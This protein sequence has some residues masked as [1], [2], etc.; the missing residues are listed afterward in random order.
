VT[1]ALPTQ[2]PSSFY[3]SEQAASEPGMLAPTLRLEYITALSAGDFNGDGAVDAADYGALRKRGGTQI[4]YNLWR[5]NYGAFGT[6]SEALSIESQV[7][8]PAGLLLVLLATAL[9]PLALLRSANF[10][11]AAHKKT[12]Y[13]VAIPHAG[14]LNINLASAVRLT[15][16]ALSNCDPPLSIVF[17]AF[18]VH[19]GDGKG[20]PVRQRQGEEAS[21]VRGRP[22][23]WHLGG[24]G[25]DH[26]LSL[27]GHRYTNRNL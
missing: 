15:S 11:R 18:A 22:A 27:Q 26:H 16:T 5:S 21:R 4:E 1:R 13:E 19:V 9:T 17:R 3:T 10:R 24:M 8:E 7:P 12:R 6:G 23:R 20:W 2:Y 25:G 14:F